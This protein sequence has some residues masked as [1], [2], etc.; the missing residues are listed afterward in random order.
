MVLDFTPLTEQVQQ[1]AASLDQFVE[2]SLHYVFL[3]SMGLLALFV[4]IFGLWACRRADRCGVTLE[5]W[6]GARLL[7]SSTNL[8]PVEVLLRVK[9]REAI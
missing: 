7:L 4:S 9:E 6:F 5:E 8:H 3:P 2:F 1:F